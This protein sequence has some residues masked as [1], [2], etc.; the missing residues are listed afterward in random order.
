MNGVETISDVTAEMRRMM[1]NACGDWADRTDHAARPISNSLRDHFAGQALPAVLVK[2]ADA[3]F[4]EHVASW[5]YSIADAMLAE[6][7][8]ATEQ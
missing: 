1:P 6:R 7:S 2:C 5:A 4:V 3:D 8:K